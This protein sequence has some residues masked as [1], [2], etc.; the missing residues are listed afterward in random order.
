MYPDFDK[1]VTKSKHLGM[2]TLIATNAYDIESRL[3]V[4]RENVDVVFVSLDGVQSTHNRFRGLP[5][6]YD[7][8]LSNI[9]KMIALGIPVRISTVVSRNNMNDLVNIIKEVRNLGAFQIHFTI[10]VNVGRAA[11]GEMQLSTFEYRKMTELIEE[12]RMKYEKEGFVITSRRNGRLSQGSEPCYG[13]TRMAHMTASAVLSPCS[14]ISKCQL[15]EKYSIQWK[16]GNLKK[17][18]SHIKTFQMLCKVREEYFGHSSC[19]ALASITAGNNETYN[20]DP[21]E[22]IW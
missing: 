9:K 21:L 11:S 6:A 16:P 4:I 20:K 1:L 14:Y 18:M 8:S 13:G 3:D 7:K 10:L 22:I 15:G 2:A 12:L 17:C 19:A 5:D